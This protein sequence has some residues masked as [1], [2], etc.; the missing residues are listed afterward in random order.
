MEISDISGDIQIPTI[1][2]LSIFMKLAQTLEALH[3]CT[4]GIKLLDK[5]DIFVG[6][7]SNQVS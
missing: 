1:S 6:V 2:I 4:L 5:K 3:S 7:R